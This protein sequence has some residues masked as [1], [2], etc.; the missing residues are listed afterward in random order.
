MISTGLCNI[1]VH[2]KESWPVFPYFKAPLH[3]TLFIRRPCV[4]SKLVHILM[5]RQYL[6][7]AGYH[8]CLQLIPSHCG[9]FGNEAT[10]VASKAAHPNDSIFNMPHS[11]TNAGSTVNAATKYMCLLPHGHCRVTIIQISIRLTLTQRERE[12]LGHAL[13]LL[14]GCPSNMR[15]IL[16][17]RP[18]IDRATI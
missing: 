4:H 7:A 1:S 15:N 13:S 16:G 10:D 12:R 5:I 2:I 17:A 8:L 14:N 6:V 9:I 11:R 3:A 18:S